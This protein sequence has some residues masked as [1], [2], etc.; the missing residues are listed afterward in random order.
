M[1]Y[2]VDMVYIAN[3]VCTHNM[4]YTVEMVY[5]VLKIS[6]ITSIGLLAIFCAVWWV[7]VIIAITIITKLH[8]IRKIK[9]S[10]CLT[11]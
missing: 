11:F 1:V 7:V 2:T 3:M 8:H 6:N 10:F 5:T 9:H 4:V